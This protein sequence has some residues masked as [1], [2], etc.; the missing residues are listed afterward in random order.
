MKLD[1]PS[2]LLSKEAC[3][4]SLLAHGFDLSSHTILFYLAVPT[5]L[6]PANFFRFEVGSLVVSVPLLLVA[7]LFFHGKHSKSFASSQSVRSRD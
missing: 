5:T 7:E 4:P 1:I 3:N 6:P 2:R